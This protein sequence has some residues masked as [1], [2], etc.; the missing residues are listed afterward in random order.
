MQD[1]ATLWQAVLDKLELNVSNVSFIMWFKPLKVL[2]FSDENK[3]IVVST[4][5]SSAKNQ[6]MRNYFDKLSSAI[7]D[8]FGETIEIEILD[9]NEE[10]EF[11]K[12]HGEKKV[13]KEIEVAKNPFKEKYTFDN[14]VV[15]KSN[16]FVYA[17]A[18]AVADRKSV[19]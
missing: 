7:K 4:N 19:V 11:I 1:L 14:F 13:Q 9:P 17:A 16:Q 15:G 5:S 6:I 10:I 8:I 3:K 18:R 2:D 12:K